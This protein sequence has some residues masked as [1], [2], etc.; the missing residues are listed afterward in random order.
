[1]SVTGYFFKLHTYP[2]RDK[3]VRFAPIILAR[4]L[5]WHPP[6]MRPGGLPLA[7]QYGGLTVLALVVCVAAWIS[8]RRHRRVRERRLRESLPDEPPDFLKTL[9]S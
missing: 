1:M 5:S 4:T 6:G 7:L 8:A 9:T 2:S 3:K